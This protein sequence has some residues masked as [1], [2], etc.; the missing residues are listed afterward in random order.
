MTTKT[1]R[2]TILSSPSFKAFLT[3]EAKK[4][5]VSVSELVRRRCENPTLSADDKVLAE[6]V[7]QVN[8]SIKDTSAKLQRSL[9]KAETTL[10]A[11][12]E[13]RH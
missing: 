5:G 9:N 1:E 10:R 13:A 8:A 12:S 3:K 6:L 7:S 4:E 11:L 2:I